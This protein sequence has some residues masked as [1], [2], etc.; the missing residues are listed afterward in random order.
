VKRR[1]ATFLFGEDIE[2]DSVCI[3]P[4]V[5]DGVVCREAGVLLDIF[6]P[7]REDLLDE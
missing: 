5:V 1:S 3:E 2:S 7:A 6:S 4:N